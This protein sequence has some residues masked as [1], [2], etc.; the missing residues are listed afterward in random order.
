[1]AAQYKGMARLLRLLYVA[2]HCPPLAVEALRI[3]LTTVMTTFN[4]S[5]YLT[6]HKKLLDATAR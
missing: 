3:A 1:M 5:L 6:I 4:T 2:D